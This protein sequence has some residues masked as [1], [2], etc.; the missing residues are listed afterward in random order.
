MIFSLISVSVADYQFSSQATAFANAYD[1]I[2]QN[3]TVP[4]MA[5]GIVGME[6]GKRVSFAQGLGGMTNQTI[7]GIGSVSKAVTAHLL[8]MLVYEGKLNWTTPISHYMPVQFK[9]E[10]LVKEANVVDLLSMRMGLEL[11][12]TLTEDLT[13]AQMLQLGQTMNSTMGFRD[14]FLYNNCLLWLEI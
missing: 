8:S 7:H 4:G 13:A 6:N 3:L 1:Q 10:T 9:N 14:S 11:S 12:N 2:R 5:I